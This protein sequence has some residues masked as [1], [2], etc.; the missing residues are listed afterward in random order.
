MW[1]ETRSDPGASPIGV[2]DA[3]IFS[4]VS[5]FS[6]SQLKGWCSWVPAQHVSC[7]CSKQGHMVPSSYFTK[8]LSFLRWKALW[9]N[10]FAVRGEPLPTPESGV[11]YPVGV[12]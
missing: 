1:E 12:Q 8:G 2:S 7:G 6:S 10:L 9:M 4:S 5:L 3:E 11:G